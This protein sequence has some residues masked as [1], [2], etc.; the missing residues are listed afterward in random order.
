MDWNAA[1]D[2]SIKILEIAPQRKKKKGIEIWP[3]YLYESQ[4]RP[5]L[6]HWHM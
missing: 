1:M 3:A 5:T 2:F 4:D 6:L